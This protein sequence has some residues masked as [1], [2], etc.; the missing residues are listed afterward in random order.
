M[1]KIG[2]R[3]IVVIDKRKIGTIK[4]IQAFTINPYYSYYIKFNKPI[5]AFGKN[6]KYL[7]ISEGISM[8]R[9]KQ[10]SRIRQILKLRRKN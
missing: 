6:E 9:L 4:K 5:S 8:K 1:L 2:D 10:N 7:W 3:V